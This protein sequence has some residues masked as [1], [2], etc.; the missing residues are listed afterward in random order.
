MKSDINPI[1]DPSVHVFKPRLTQPEEVD[2]ILMTLASQKAAASAS[3]G[4]VHRKPSP[5]LPDYYLFAPGN[6]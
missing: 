3:Y 4:L 5:R 2:H 1:P 6:R